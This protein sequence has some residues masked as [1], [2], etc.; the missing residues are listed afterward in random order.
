[1]LSGCT[2]LNNISSVVSPAQ[3][4]TYTPSQSSKNY[5][6]EVTRYTALQKANPNDLDILISLS[7]NHRY[8]GDG[9]AAQ[10]VLEST[11]A[12]FSEHS[13]Y[14]SELG[15][16]LLATGDINGAQ[17][18]L[19]KATILDSENW[20]AYAALG[21][22]Y[23]L[24]RDFGKAKA[25][26]E[27]ALNACPDSISLRNN[28]AISAGM[29][30]DPDKALTILRALAIEAP[31]EQTVAGN[32]AQFEHMQKDCVDCPSEKYQAIT[33][34]IYAPGIGSISDEMACMITVPIQQ[35]EPQQD[36][37]V[38]AI[39]D[40]NFIDAQIQFEFDSAVLTTNSLPILDSV[41]RAIA[42]P[43]LVDY[44]FII[45]GHTDA[46]GT[47]QY[48]QTLSEQRAQAVKK[49]LVD[50]GEIDN[51][52]LDVIGYGETHLIDTDNPEAEINRRVRITRLGKVN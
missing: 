23:D 33:S 41:A 50:S 10:G 18:S 42:G 14:Q 6:Q 36:P 29:S 19:R 21:V 8:G 31:A 24:M 51:R 37:I 22:V 30:G 52:R 9:L 20:D 13:D 5:Q 39:E 2:V 12:Q 11:A 15:K 49:Y 1:M 16:V 3:T 45:E 34:S 28:M 48:N 25:A 35:A 44:R 17:S 32:I 40:N 43:D 26:Y 46:R 47:D 27:M 4:S 7:R 38:Q